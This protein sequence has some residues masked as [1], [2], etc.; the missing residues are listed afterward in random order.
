KLSPVVEV[1]QLKANPLLVPSTD[2]LLDGLGHAVLIFGPATMA[3][4]LTNEQYTRN[5][6]TKSPLLDAAM[7]YRITVRGA[8]R[9]KALGFLDVDPVDQGVKNLRTGDVVQFQDGRTLPIKVRI[10]EGAFG[11]RNPDHVE[12][13]VPTHITTPTGTLDVTT[14]TFF[15]GARFSDGWLPQGAVEAG[16]DQVVVTIERVPVH[17]ATP[18]TTCLQSGLLELEGCYRFRTDP[19]LHQFGPFRVNVIEGVCFE[20]P[21]HTQAPFQLHRRAEDAEGNPTGPTV[22]LEDADAPFLRCDRFAV[23]PPL[24]TLRDLS[25]GRLQEFAS[26]G[27]HAVL[28]GI[29]RLVTP[30]ALHAVDL[31]A[32]GSTDGFSRTGYARGVTMVK[33]AATDNQSATAGMSALQDLEV[34]L[35][36]SHPTTAPLVGAPVT[37]TVGAGGGR[38]GG[39]SS[40]QMST[41]ATGCAQAPW[42][43]GSSAGVNTLQATALAFGSPQTF[44]ATG[45]PVCD[46]W[47]TKASMPT[48]RNALAVGVID[49]VLYA[50]GGI[51]AGGAVATVEAYDPASNTWTT[52]APLPTARHRLAVGVVNGILYAVGGS[53]NL[54]N[55]P[56]VLATVEEYDPATNSWT[57]RASM[58]T[59][60]LDLAVGVVNGILYAVGGVGSLIPGLPT[61]EAY[62]PATDTWT[63]KAPMPTARFG[64]G[65]AAI[66]G[67]LYAVGGASNAP[68]GGQYATVEVYDP[69][70]DT[71][72][73][74]ASMSATRHLLGLGAINRTLYAVGGEGS[75]PTLN[76]IVGSVEAYDP[77]TD[78]WTTKAVMPTARAFLGVGV[79]SGMLYAVGGAGPGFTVL[80][81]VEAYQP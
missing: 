57:T 33:T 47:T 81:S 72:T 1:C 42:T 54:G 23:T 78:L 32:G 80:R 15:A 66:N 59:A 74:K 79:V 34:C 2:C 43:L 77:V 40:V 69:A 62:D 46:C 70:T 21:I 30:Q 29:G 52:K 71:W 8:P 61:V 65:V 56:A 10:Q 55:P 67:K 17:D 5:W 36:T 27:W 38:V 3:L 45:V 26:A 68:N 58:P 60:R 51:G 49:G 50:V 13:V 41:G 64:L 39:A 75:I 28:R 22:A 12:Q 6:D 48:A 37:F 31:G 63:T 11:S 16:I 14:T 20:L 9:G 4:D 19:D 76:T 24:L 25:S 53:G 44:T 73:T 7:F 35:T 18:A